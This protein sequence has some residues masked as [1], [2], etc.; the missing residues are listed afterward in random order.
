[1]KLCAAN[2][3]TTYECIVC[4]TDNVRLKLNRDGVAAPSKMLSVPEPVKAKRENLSLWALVYMVPA[5]P[6]SI[7]FSYIFGMMILLR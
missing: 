6:A 4:I 2:M 7:D 3:N 5:L 1:M